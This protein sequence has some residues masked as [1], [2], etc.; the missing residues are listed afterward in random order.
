MEGQNEKEYTPEFQYGIRIMESENLPNYIFLLNLNLNLIFS[1]E[2]NLVQKL[3][4][5]LV[6]KL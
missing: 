3:P 5:Q 1:P 2:T 4:C 6:R